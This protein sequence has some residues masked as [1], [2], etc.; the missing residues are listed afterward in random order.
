MSDDY[1]GLGLGREMVKRLVDVARAEG[2]ERLVAEV[3]T[4]NS[5]MV[6]ICDELGFAIHDEDGGDTLRAE[7]RLRQLRY[8]VGS[9]GRGRRRGQA[10]GPTG[11]AWS[12][13]ASPARATPAGC[14]PAAGPGP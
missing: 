1:Q 14:A 13:S 3:L 10:A 5:G 7:L 8:P 9:E 2:V 11:P 6:R 12:G 4:C